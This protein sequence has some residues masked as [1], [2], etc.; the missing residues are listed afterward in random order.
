M[1]ESNAKTIKEYLIYHDK[2]KQLYGNNTFIL[3][4]VGSFYEVHCLE[5]LDGNTCLGSDLDLL[6]DLTD[7]IKST[8]QVVVHNSEI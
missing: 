2:Y 1:K 8:R 7:L 4:E 6:S 5:S 3:M